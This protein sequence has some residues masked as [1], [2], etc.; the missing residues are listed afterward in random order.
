MKRIFIA[1]PMG[2][3]STREILEERAHAE[4]IAGTILGEIELIHSW[5]PNAKEHLNAVENLG[6]SIFLLGSADV[7]VFAPGWNEARGCLI[8]H[9]VAEKYGIKILD[10][11]NV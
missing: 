7:A 2:D 8:E 5:E 6:R 3:K 11:S 1:Q 4:K 9:E 10:L